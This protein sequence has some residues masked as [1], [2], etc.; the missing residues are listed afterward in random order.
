M[1]RKQQSAI[2]LAGAGVAAAGVAAAWL[3]RRHLRLVHGPSEAPVSQLPD[4]AP[5]LSELRRAEPRLAEPRLAEFRDTEPHVVDP[6]VESLR[7]PLPLQVGEPEQTEGYDAVDPE[8]LGSV[9]LE[10]A[11]QT[12]DEP[13]LSIIDA[14][15]APEV[16]D[17][18]ISDAS[19]RAARSPEEVIEEE[20]IE[21]DD[22][23]LDLSELDELGGR[24]DRD[25]HKP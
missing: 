7:A 16:E 2:V 13:K 1:N 15:L 9:W 12:A 18:L 23:D 25:L 17:F 4:S 20:I 5:R 3:G 24:D 11:T 10:R 8:T 22:L 14:S 19:R 6:R 21:D